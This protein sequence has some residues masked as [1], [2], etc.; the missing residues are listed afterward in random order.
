MSTLT[1]YSSE[2]LLPRHQGFDNGPDHGKQ[3][4]QLTNVGVDASFSKETGGS[5][6]SVLQNY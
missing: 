1:H 4:Q 5:T 2:L 3:Q 6:Y